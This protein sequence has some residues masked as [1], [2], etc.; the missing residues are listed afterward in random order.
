MTLTLLLAIA[1]LQDVRQETVVERI[2]LTPEES[3]AVSLLVNAGREARRCEAHLPS[4]T[5]AAF[6]TA[7]ARIPTNPE[8]L[9]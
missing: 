5:R 9:L 2:Q 3:E 7:A 8:T 1:A 6:R 4:E